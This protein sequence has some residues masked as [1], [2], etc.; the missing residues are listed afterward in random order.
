MTSNN[1]LL[2][3]NNSSAD[4][5]QY[6]ITENLDRLES[7]HLQHIL[8]TTKIKRIIVYSTRIINPSIYPPILLTMIPR[9]FQLGFL[10][11]I[12]NT[13]REEF[14]TVG[15]VT[16]MSKNSTFIYIKGLQTGDIFRRSPVN[17]QL[18]LYKHLQYTIVYLLTNLSRKIQHRKIEVK[19]WYK[20][21]TYWLHQ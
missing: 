1:T 21:T 19:E 12:T 4:I 20:R 13:F 2:T 15:R 18:V 6:L 11:Q 5:K 16:K 3:S 7:I 14:E 17:L 10:F 8:T 9:W